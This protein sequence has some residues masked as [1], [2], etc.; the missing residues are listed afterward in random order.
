MGNGPYPIPPASSPPPKHHWSLA[1]L[2]WITVVIMIFTAWPFVRDWI[3]KPENPLR[4]SINKGDSI[5]IP[6]S[7]NYSSNSATPLNNNTGGLMPSDALMLTNAN[8]GSN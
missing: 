3:K 5:Y 4:P 6:E 7:T 2:F 8:T 1:P